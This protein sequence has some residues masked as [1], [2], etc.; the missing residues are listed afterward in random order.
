MYFLDDI[1]VKAKKYALKKF[2]KSDYLKETS[3][4]LPLT[5][6]TFLTRAIFNFLVTSR[7]Q[8]NYYLINFTISIIVTIIFTLLSPFFYNLFTYS[9]ENE[10]NDFT[11][12]IIDS[13]WKDGWVFYEYWKVRILGTL[14]TFTILLLFFIEINSIM[15]QNFILHAMISSAIVDLIYNYKLKE[16]EPQP[17]I[18]VLSSM[19]MIESYYPD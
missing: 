3:T 9:I 14:G 10:V 6:L 12:H 2:V 18:K 4:V 5:L 16:E 1:K 15:I 11:K 8:T 7:L 13:F 17:K 19:N